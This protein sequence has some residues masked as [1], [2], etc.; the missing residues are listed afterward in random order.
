M[1]TFALHAPNFSRRWTI[2]SCATKGQQCLQQTKKSSPSNIIF[3]TPREARHDEEYWMAAWLRAESQ[4]E[5][6]EN[7]R[8]AESNR[9]KFAQQ[10][11]NA[12]T[13]RYNAN[14]GKKCLC[15]IVKNENGEVKPSIPKSVAGSLDL[16]IQHL[17][18][19]ETFPGEWLKH[20]LLCLL[21]T[22]PSIRYGYIANLCIAKY[23]RRQ[24]VASVIIDY[25][26]SVAKSNG[27]EKVFV[28][29]HRHNKPARNLYQK[30]G[31]Q[32]VDAASTQLSAEQTFL[33]CLELSS[34]D[35]SNG[36]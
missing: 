9:R 35:V 11:F 8:Y 29:V 1:A 26:I 7:E 33:L 24:G 10:E 2:V 30:I 14:M 3:E 27:A 36:R 18:H 21:D 31:F 6:R 34:S 16:S 28:H 13:R 32:V 4:W 12:M 20:P 5:G 25:A 22:K 19:G 15:I 23:A 17:S